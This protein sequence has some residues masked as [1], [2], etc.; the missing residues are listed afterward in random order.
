MTINKQEVE[1][2]ASL[3]MLEFSDADLPKMQQDLNKILSYVD[4]LN[5]VDITN[6]TPLCHPINKDIKKHAVR[7]DIANNE[8][9]HELY[10]Q[11]APMI[12]QNYYLIPNV[13][14][15]KT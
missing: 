4:I 7:K 6:V 12:D 8:D 3:A 13:F 9:N 1:H 15:D 2:I 5:E 11:L 10:Q 14:E